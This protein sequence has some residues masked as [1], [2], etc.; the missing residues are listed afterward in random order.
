MSRVQQTMTRL[1]ITNKDWGVCGFT[2][3]LYAMYELNPATRPQI[4]N[5][6]AAYRILAEI[7]TYLMML[8]AE[9]SSLLNDIRDFTRSF[10]NEFAN[11]EIDTY[12]AHINKAAA[13]G[14]SRH[15]ILSDSLYSIALPP[16][17][18]ADYIERIWGWKTTISEFALGT[19]GGDGIIGVSS[20]EC[21]GTGAPKPY[22]GL[23]HYM[24]RSGG[25][26]YSWGQSFS[27][28]QQA[29]RDGAGGVLWRV[30]YV[31][32]VARP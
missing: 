21:D 2:S 1:G 16:K 27:S 11:F 19:G 10:G 15:Q 17:A 29:A 9:S 23:E 6:T 28:V 18:V 26:I 22:H 12:I 20:S 8:K 32:S 7:K 5:A 31:I 30:C 24:Y 13:K 4:I 14:K 3:S 25:K